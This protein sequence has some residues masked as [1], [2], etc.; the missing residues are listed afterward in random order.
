[1]F[2]THFLE[3]LKCRWLV[4]FFLTIDKKVHCVRLLKAVTQVTIVFYARLALQ[5]R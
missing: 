2:M 1:M 5:D 4:A 3:L